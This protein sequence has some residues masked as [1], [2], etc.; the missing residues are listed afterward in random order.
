MKSCGKE[1]QTLCS[2]PIEE[3][4]YENEVWLSGEP[5]EMTWSSCNDST[6]LLQ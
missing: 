3:M 4:V 2:G 6:L 1:D 5:K